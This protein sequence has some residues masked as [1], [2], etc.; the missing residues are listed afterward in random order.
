MFFV[1]SKLLRFLIEPLNWVMAFLLIGLIRRNTRLGRRLLA[2]GVVMAVFFT[3]PLVLNLVT[4]A[5]EVDPVLFTAI[6]VPFDV[7]IVLG[8]FSRVVERFPDRLHLNEHPNRFIHAIELYKAGKI[9][10]ILVTGGSAALVGEKRNDSE[11][12]RQF[13]VKSGIPPLDILVEARSRN[14]HE[15]AVLSAELLAETMPGARCLL[16]TSAFHMRRAAGCFRKEGIQ[17]TPFATDLSE[18]AIDTW[19]PDAVIVPKARGF[20]QWGMLV[21]EWVGMAVYKARGYI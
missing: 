12:V 5:W 16:I 6:D 17:A 9:R 4:R 18:D 7:G 8:G 13:L 1:L 10:K 19:T 20:E 11:M 15:N 2:A 21:K 3:N 14:T